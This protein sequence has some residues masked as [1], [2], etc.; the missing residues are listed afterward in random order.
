MIYGA[1]H[2]NFTLNFYKTQIN[3]LNASL[4]KA[5]MTMMMLNQ[6]N[7]KLDMYYALFTVKEVR[8]LVLYNPYYYYYYWSQRLLPKKS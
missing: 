4:F 1:S 5:V 2:L 7:F 6:F 8:I 3:V